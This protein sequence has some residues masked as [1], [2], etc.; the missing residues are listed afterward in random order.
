MA[1]SEWVAIVLWELL[2]VSA[3]SIVAMV[4]LWVVLPIIATCNV[5]RRTQ[6]DK[7]CSYG[8]AFCEVYASVFQ[9]AF[10]VQTVVER[11]DWEQLTTQP[12]K[13]EVTAT[14]G[15]GKEEEEIAH[16]IRSKDNNL[17]PQSRNL[18]ERYQPLCSS[19]G[20]SLM[21]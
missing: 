4:A 10:P 21:I 3:L 13:R 2:P 7:K 12:E 1:S 8:D 11:V 17:S 18:P 16:Q 14:S 15:Q 9:A 5:Y 6:Q 19:L 20:E